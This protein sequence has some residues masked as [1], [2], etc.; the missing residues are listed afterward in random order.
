MGLGKPGPTYLKPSGEYPENTF[1]TVNVPGH[2]LVDKFTMEPVLDADNCNRTAQY[3][4]ALQ[5]STMFTRENTHFDALWENQVFPLMDYCQDLG[6]FDMN[7][8]DGKIEWS[9]TE[10]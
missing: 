1:D 8:I 3:Y 9:F 2:P 5:S 6:N 7:V 10:K 4:T